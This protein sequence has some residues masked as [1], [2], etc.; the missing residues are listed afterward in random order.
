MSLTKQTAN[1]K[2]ARGWLDKGFAGTDD[3]I[4]KQT[5]LDYRFGERA[6]LKVKRIRTADCVVGGFRYAQDS[7]RVGS[8][9]LGLYNDKGLLDHVGFTSA[10][11]KED[12][13]AL[14]ARLE[15]LV[16]P[17]GFTGDAPDQ[18]DGRQRVR[19][20]GCPWRPSLSWRSV[21]IIP[22]SEGFG[23]GRD[24][25][26]GAGIRHR[27]SAPWRGSPGPLP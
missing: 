21:S 2:T 14:T 26:A 13:K 19:R 18:A 4:A 17:A 22:R 10:F 8:F 27:N 9:L 24:C 3:V 5:D 20:S 25:C 16:G 1:V 6:I 7:E 11:E 23:K 12:R 15:K